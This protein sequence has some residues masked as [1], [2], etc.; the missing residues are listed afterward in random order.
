MSR[1][2]I[3]YFDNLN[4][5]AT[6]D[7]S[8]FKH[9]EASS[10]EKMTESICQI[11]NLFFNLCFVS[12]SNSSEKGYKIM[13]NNHSPWNIT[14]FERLVTKYSPVEKYDLIWSKIDLF[15]WILNVENNLC[16]HDILEWL[17]NSGDKEHFATT[18]SWYIYPWLGIHIS[19][20][21]VNSILL[22]RTSS[23]PISWWLVSRRV[24][25]SYLN[26]RMT[27]T[28]VLII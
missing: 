8:Y 7:N 26:F 5:I 27:N 1:N 14:F 22:Q 9:Y 3:Q 21:F 16:E 17:L 25:N 10:Y 13:K 18:I 11:R 19:D 4:K 23:H 15:K 2:R 20:S 24:P 6:T 12:H 28:R